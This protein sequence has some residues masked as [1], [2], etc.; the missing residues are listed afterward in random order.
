M[1]TTRMLILMRHAKSGYPSG[2]RD[3]DR[4]LAERGEREGAL[5]GE[6]LRAH[7]PPID[8]VLSST[9]ARTLGTVAVTGVP[10][11]I[12]TAAE[13][14]EAAPEMILDQIRDTGA[15]VS[16]LLVV[17]HSP[18][19]PGLAMELAGDRS[20]DE[21]LARLR[22]RFP[23]AAIAVL[24]TENEWPDLAYGEARLVAFHIPRG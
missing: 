7:L 10:A 16:T 13:I 1:T 20:L 14:Y 12:R 15:A 21:P 18:G 6:W 4:P 17:G 8:A 2:V 11:P 23:T 24:E 19:M 9:A 3:H 5:A 22:T